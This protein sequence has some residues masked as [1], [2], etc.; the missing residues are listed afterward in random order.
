MKT[1]T[2]SALLLSL[3]AAGHAQTPAP[4]RQ[5]YDDAADAKAEIAKA[6]SRAQRDHRR[7]LLVFG[8]N[9]CGDCLALDRSFHEAPAAGIIEAGFIVVHV[10]IGRFDLNKDVA[11][12]YQIPLEKGVPAVAV[13]DSDGTLLYS[14][15]NGEFEPAGRME[16]QVFID[17]LNKWKP[18]AGDG[19]P[20]LG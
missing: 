5:P 19:G 9:W 20:T 8:G 2:V 3:A 13:L 10:S 14:Q 16:P 17:F 7:L 1:L 15:R 4:V 11:G 6:V 12:K 18:R